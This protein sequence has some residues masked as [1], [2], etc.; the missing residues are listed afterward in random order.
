MAF[1]KRIPLSLG[2]LYAVGMGN[3]LLM[4][5]RIRVNPIHSL[6][7]AGRYV[8]TKKAGNK[9]VI[10]SLLCTRKFTALDFSV[11]FVIF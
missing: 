4:L 6:T 8:Y 5:E 2:I 11:S 10:E 9:H 7:D 3:K 1:Y